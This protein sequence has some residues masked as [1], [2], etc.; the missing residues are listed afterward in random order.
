MVQG[1]EQSEGI[2]TACI[3]HFEYIDP[4][5][6]AFAVTREDVERYEGLPVATDLDGQWMAL[7]LYGREIRCIPG[8]A[9]GAVGAEAVV[10]RP[11]DLARCIGITR[12]SC[13]PLSQTRCRG[14]TIFVNLSCGP[15]SSRQAIDGHRRRGF[16]IHY[17]LGIGKLGAGVE[18][19]SREAD[20][21]IQR[22]TDLAQQHKAVATTYATGATATTGS[23]TGGSRL[24]LQGR[25]DAGFDCG[26]QLLDI[27]QVA[28][29]RSGGFLLLR[30]GRLPIA[31]SQ[32]L[33]IEVQAAVAPEGENLTIGESDR[34]RAACTSNQLLAG[35]DTIAFD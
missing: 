18:P 29:R 15:L 12:P 11:R 4:Y 8:E 19:R 20:Y 28:V 2:G 23:R 34:N 24:A 27:G 5:V 16:R 26:L 31:T 14:I 10:E 13:V 25:V 9:T 6:L 33:L 1:L 3:G 35:I 7:R 21:R 22:T 32:H 30:L 17:G